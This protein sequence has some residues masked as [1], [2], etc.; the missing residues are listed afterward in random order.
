MQTGHDALSQDAQLLDIVFF[1]AR[2]SYHG[3]S[4]KQVTV[5]R[6]SAE[7]EYRSM[8]ATA[9]ELTWLRY[10]LQDLQVPHRQPATL[11]C[12]NKAALYIAANQFYH[13]RTKHIEL[14]CHTVREK[15]QNGEIKTTHVKTQFQVADIFTKPLPAPLFQSYLHKLGVIDIYTPT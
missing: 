11:L 1:L 15:I 4:K 10:L 14:D 13:E 7:A 6:S 2:P 12:D 3:K 5:S 8:A 9:C